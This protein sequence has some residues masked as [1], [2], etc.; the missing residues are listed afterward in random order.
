MISM[1]KFYLKKILPVCL[2]ASP[3]I[4]P[5]STYIQVAVGD[6]MLRPA[7]HRIQ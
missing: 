1:I 5:K 6:M 3:T 2:A 7:K 4:L